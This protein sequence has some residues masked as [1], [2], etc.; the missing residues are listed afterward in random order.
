MRKDY[1][2]VSDAALAADETAFVEQYWTNNWKENTQAHDV[3][4]LADREEYQL[5]RP[6]IERLPRGSRILDGG[7]G[8]GEWTVFFGQQGLDA[9][10]LDLSAE[11]VRLLQTRFPERQF[12]HG[13]IRHTGF[14]DGSFNACFAWGTFE[15]FE[16]G[17]GDCLNEVH[18]LLPPGGLLVMSV[19]FQNWRHTLRDRRP[20]ARWDA[21][22]DPRDGYR[23]PHRF[24]QWRFT[25][26]ELQRELE[27]RGF[28]T[29]L[30][31]PIGKSA[32]VGRWLQWDFPI[33]RKGTRVFAIARRL[34][35]MILP[36][37]Y[38]SHMLL[39]VAERRE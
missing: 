10:G 32:G 30:V 24:Y 25:R 7:C 22:F 13:D 27:L 31:A 4:A 6:F 26:T 23:Q 14:P 1:L 39:A 12:A 37:S 3:S 11:T 34:F 18:R 20:L 9:V 15:H 2:P 5:M 19:P 21:G 29:H 17:L 16:S 36:A 28:R 8:L 38:V 35:S 33:A